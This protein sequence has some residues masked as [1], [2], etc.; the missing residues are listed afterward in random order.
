MPYLP[1]VILLMLIYMASMIGLT[2]PHQQS[3]F[4][5]YTPYIILLNVLL[6][7]LYHRP[8]QRA[9]F[10]FLHLGLL[11][12][13]GIEG[14][15]VA[16]QSLYGPYVFGPS[17]GPTWQGVPWVMPLYWWVLAYSSGVLADR[18]KQSPMVLKVG[19]G[20][21]LMA[22]LAVL[23]Q[24]VAAPLDFWKVASS[25]RYGLGWLLGGLV[26][27]WAWQRWKVAQSNAVAVYVYGGLLIFFAGIWLFLK[28]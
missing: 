23:I 8:F 28:V 13:A 22:G 2:T 19:L 21:V 5:Y 20:A 6:L 15:A 25:W 9:F 3:W 27:Q 14:L 10:L 12:G 4:L 7:V 24:Q 11:V 26:L 17:L 18:L 1:A 16:T